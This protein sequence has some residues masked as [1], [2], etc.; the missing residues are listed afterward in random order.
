MTLEL[1]PWGKSHER[2]GR[3]LRVT[4]RGEKRKGMARGLAGG[5]AG[6]RGH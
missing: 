5:L 1:F 6:D 4:T 2:P 3:M